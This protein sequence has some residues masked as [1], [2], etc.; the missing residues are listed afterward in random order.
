MVPAVCECSAADISGNE[1]VTVACIL[2]TECIL[3]AHGTI[4]LIVLR[5]HAGTQ[6]YLQW[7]GLLAGW[8]SGRRWLRSLCRRSPDPDRSVVFTIDATTCMI[9]AVCLCWHVPLNLDLAS[10][11]SLIVCRESNVIFKT[12]V[13]IWC[14]A[15]LAQF[16]M[17]SLLPCLPFDSHHRQTIAHT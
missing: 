8:L 12:T 11:L 9:M 1:G 3:H 6:S 17:L 14:C 5:A 7:P 15:I 16:I 10:G 13:R 2:K 4:K